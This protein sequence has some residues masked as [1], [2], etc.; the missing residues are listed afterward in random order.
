VELWKRFADFAV[1]HHYLNAQDEEKCKQILERAIDNAGQ[2]MKGS[3][4]WTKYIDFEI[5]QNHL[6]FVNL[7]CYLSVK[8]P[9]INHEEIEKK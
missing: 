2:H 1:E 8:T 4:I 7:L 3:E 5:T 6:G 9:L